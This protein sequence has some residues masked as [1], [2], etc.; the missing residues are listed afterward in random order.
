MCNY[1]FD[2]DHGVAYKIN[3]ISAAFIDDEGADYRRSIIVHTDVKV[4]NLKK[5]K[6]R[7]TL[8]HVYPSEAYDLDAAKRIFNETLLSKFVSGARRISE[9][10]YQNIK[11][12]FEV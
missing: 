7:R 4:T 9:Q 8:S 11:A 5:E 3:P 2:E 10:E 6:V 12:Q 1:F